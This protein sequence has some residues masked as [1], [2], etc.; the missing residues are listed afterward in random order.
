MFR[1]HCSLLHQGE[2]Q[3]D[4]GKLYL[5]R[6][7]VSVIDVSSGDYGFDLIEQMIVQVNTKLPLLPIFRSKSEYEF[8]K[9]S[10]KISWID[11]FNTLVKRMMLQIYR[12]RVRSAY[13]AF[14]DYQ[15]RKKFY[16]ASAIN[17]V[18]R[19]PAEI[20]KESVDRFKI[21]QNLLFVNHLNNINNLFK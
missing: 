2:R 17:F 14:P 8:D 20:E 6:I 15:I 9:K 4:T 7:F 16:K 21:E 1:E 3:P 19:M 18:R 13:F 11:Q 12:N 5:Y 10:L